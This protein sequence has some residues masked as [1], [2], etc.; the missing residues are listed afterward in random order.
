MI[1]LATIAL[2][3]NALATNALATIALATRT[4]HA[5]ARAGTGTTVHRPALIAA[6]ADVISR[7]ES[8]PDAQRSKAQHTF[9]DRLVTSLARTHNRRFYARS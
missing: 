5:A 6:I 4:A 2:A 9:H 7:E 3:T 8:R 1:V